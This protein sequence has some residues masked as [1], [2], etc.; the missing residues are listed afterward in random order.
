MFLNERMNDNDKLL[1][2]LINGIVIL[3]VMKNSF[4]FTVIF[5]RGMD[6]NCY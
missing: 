6:T 4:I 5:I 2:W 1:N 3:V